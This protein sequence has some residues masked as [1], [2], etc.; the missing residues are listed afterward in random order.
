MNIS[1]IQ[2]QSLISFCSLIAITGIGYISTIYFAHFLG[3]AIL[4]SF[5]LFLAYYGIFDLIGDG[6]FGGAAVKRISEGAEQNEYFTAFFVLRLIL[7]LVSIITFMIISPFLTGLEKDGLLGWLII[8]LV[9]GTLSS[10]TSINLY[11]TAQVGIMQVSNLINT[12]TKILVQILAVFIGFGLGGLVAGFIAGMIAALLINLNYVRLGISHFN[13][14]HFSGLL[15]FSIW[16][17]LSSGGLLIVTY[18]DT[19]IIGQFMTE[20]DVGIYR[21]AFQLSSVASF[22]VAAFHTTLYPHISRWHA[23][24]EL[25][26]IE[27]SL[28]RAFTYSFF[29]AIPVTAGGLILAE[30]LLHYL[31]GAAFEPGSQI[32]W[33]L[34]FVQIANIFMYLLTMCLNAMDM[35]KISFYCTAVSAALNIL[36]CILFIPLY[37]I[38]GAAGASLITISI[39]AVLAYIMLKSSVRISIDG[40]SVK[41]LLLSAALMSAALLVYLAIFPIREFIGLVL[42]VAI[43]AAVYFAAVLALDDRIRNDLKGLLET[44]SFPIIP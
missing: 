17:F 12:V 18:A 19:I 37:G 5:F 42:A 3:P 33:I 35:P 30:K 41:N 38:S 4:G 20:T 22:M 11:G 9:A 21:I 34:L 40:R 6:G 28:T 2:R 32:L 1:P 15:S 31:Y 23:D 14:S 44:M 43:G 25:T 16:T 13:R 27:Q 10:I 24:R 29:L 39:N 36:L 8:A 7:L 26:R